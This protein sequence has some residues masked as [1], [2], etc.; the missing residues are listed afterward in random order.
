MVNWRCT[1]HASHP[2]PIAAL[3]AAEQVKGVLSMVRKMLI[4]AITLA[5]ISAASAEQAASQAKPQYEPAPMAVEDSIAA[6]KVTT[7]DDAA[8]LAETEFANADANL[9]GAVD[10]AEFSAFASASAPADQA[11][12]S[13][14]APTAEQAFTAI[15]KGKPSFTKADLVA[16]RIASFDKADADKNKALNDTERKK[17]TELLTI[18]IA[19]AKL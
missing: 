7:R 19:P 8:K 18:K 16:A 10:Q 11:S 6:N 2:S 9:D 1:Q 15:A 3:V 4:T 12:A 14:T 5:L 13:A 17:F